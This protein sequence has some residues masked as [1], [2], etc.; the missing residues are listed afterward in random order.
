MLRAATVPKSALPDTLAVRSQGKCAT[1]IRHEENGEPPGLK[2]YRRPP[3]CI[4][5]GVILRSSHGKKKPTDPP[6]SRRYAGRGM[7]LTCYMHDGRENETGTGNTE[8]VR[9]E[10]DAQ[11]PEDVKAAAAAFDAWQ[12][13]FR[14]RKQK[15]TRVY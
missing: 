9:P 13:A 15:R 1:C 11:A 5:C 10:L 7:C 6:E 2:I 14:S 3:N 12:A 4:K 8:F